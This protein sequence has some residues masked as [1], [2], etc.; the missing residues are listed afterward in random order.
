M[1]AQTEIK[2]VQNDKL[3]SLNYTLQDSSGN[4]IDLT[5]ASLVF[6]VQRPAQTG[7]KFTGAMSILSAPAGTCFYTV[8][9]G[10]FDETGRYYAEIQVTFGSGQVLTYPNIVISVQPE[11][12]RE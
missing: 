8:Q 7:L 1:S 10:D 5:G 3:Y 6:N 12:P 9:A 4:A 2:V 11:L